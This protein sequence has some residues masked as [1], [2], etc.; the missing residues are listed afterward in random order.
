MN[1]S[2]H[3]LLISIYGN[4]PKH[5]PNN[6]KIIRFARGDKPH[7]KSCWVKCNGEMAFFN[8]FANPTPKCGVWKSDAHNK[9]YNAMNEYQKKIYHE[10]MAK[11]QERKE[12]EMQLEKLIYINEQWKLYRI[13]GSEKEA[14]LFCLQSIPVQSVQSFQ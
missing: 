8:D 13:E 2:L 5:I 6:G 14:A 11:E 9:M 3:D 7:S 10:E 12:K 4:A 1:L